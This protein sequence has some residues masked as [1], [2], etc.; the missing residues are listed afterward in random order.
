MINCSGLRFSARA[1]I[2]KV[3]DE[4]ICDNRGI[5]LKN[6][7]KPRKTNETMKTQSASES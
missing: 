1:K 2:S 6:P 4:V 7:K 3:E 5:L